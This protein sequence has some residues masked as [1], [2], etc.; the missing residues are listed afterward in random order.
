[1]QPK[2]Q[3]EQN[4]NGILKYLRQYMDLR[5]GHAARLS[6]KIR[7]AE[8]DIKWHQLDAMRSLLYKMRPVGENRYAVADLLASFN[9]DWRRDLFKPKGQLS[10]MNEIMTGAAE[11]TS[12]ATGLGGIRDLRTFYQAIDPALKSLVE[13]MQTWIWWDIA[14]AGDMSLFE[15]QTDRLRILLKSQLNEGLLAFYVKEMKK[16]EQSFSNPSKEDILDFEFYRTEGLVRAVEYRRG[17]DEAHQQIIAR[18]ATEDRASDTLVMQLA[19]HLRAQEMLRANQPLDASLKEY[20]GK[21]L[22]CEPAQVAP[23][24][25]LEFE[26]RYVAQAK[27]EIVAALQQGDGGGAPY[28]FKLRQLADLQKRIE[29]LRAEVKPRAQAKTESAATEDRGAF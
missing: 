29:V 7:T 1:M 9:A 16:G 25:A 28:N 17:N 11:E 15:T 27:Q 20:Y 6:P 2:S 18:E 19:Q 4:A 3:T 14:D 24:K 26:Q 21:V 8:A 10:I 5:F 22:K 23:E 12:K 13:L